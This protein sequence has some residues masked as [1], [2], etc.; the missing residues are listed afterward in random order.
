MLTEQ[1]TEIVTPV[2]QQVD[3]PAA[4]QT[5]SSAYQPAARPAPVP[6]SDIEPASGKPRVDTS[7][8]SLDDNWVPPAAPQPFPVE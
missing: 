1:L 6:A 8:H 7:G 3:Q 5:A 2:Q 4:R